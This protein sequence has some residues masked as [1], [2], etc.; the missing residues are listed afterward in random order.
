MDESHF[1]IATDTALQKNIGSAGFQRTGP[2]TWSRRIGEYLNV[3]WL[4][5]HST[6]KLY[7]VN[8]GIHYAFLPKAGTEATL[9]EDWIEQPDCEIKLRLTSDPS[10]KDQWWP[11]TEQTADEIGEIAGTRGLAI[12]DSYRLTGPIAAMEAEEIET[13]TAGLL[14]DLTKVRACL[15]LARLHEHLG[16]KDKCVDAATR[17]IRLA[18]MAA[19]PKKA[20]KEILKRCEK[21]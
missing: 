9:S 13:G 3:I 4:Q 10:A 14:S 15:L 17:G 18:G 11:L 2:G 16:N 7:C 20:L 21:Q 8:I 12:F 1:L 6:E 19:G 5:R